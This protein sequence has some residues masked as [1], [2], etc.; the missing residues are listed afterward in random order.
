MFQKTKLVKKCL[1]R[2]RHEPLT[3]DEI[4]RYVLKESDE[5]SILNDK[6]KFLAYMKNSICAIVDIMKINS[7][8]EENGK[9]L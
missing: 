9:K 1:L 3:R 6:R 2:Q 8:V 4:T 5:L 7:F